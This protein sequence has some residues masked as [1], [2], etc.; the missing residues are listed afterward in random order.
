MPFLSVT[1]SSRRPVSLTSY[2][3]NDIRLLD[4]GEATV[5]ID[6]S[7]SLIDINH[8]K[9][10]IVG[11]KKT[12]KKSVSTVLTNSQDINNNRLG[13]R[14]LKQS[15]SLQLGFRK[16]SS[17]ELL[18]SHCDRSF[19]GPILIDV[20]LSW[21]INRPLSFIFATKFLQKESD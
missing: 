13:R 9:S 15:Q 18:P 20:G 3:Y 16:V 10:A 6:N 12:V 1:T 11:Q 17:N 19:A 5:N 14:Q 2:V 8:L 21:M 4:P 7:E